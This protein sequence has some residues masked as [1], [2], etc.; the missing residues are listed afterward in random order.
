MTAVCDVLIQC[1]DELVENVQTFKSMLIS[2]SIHSPFAIKF[3]T[4]DILKILSGSYFQ[5]SGV[6]VIK[7]L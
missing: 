6:E 1:A 5:T 7:I 4:L 2:A 3:L